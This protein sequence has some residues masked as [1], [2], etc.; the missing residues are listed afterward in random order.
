MHHSQSAWCIAA[1]IVQRKWFAN[2]D[3]KVRAEDF[4][5][6]NC[7]CNCLRRYSCRQ[8]EVEKIGDSSEVLEHFY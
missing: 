8:N 6:W 1:G 5:P 3:F 7:G 4:R 2:D